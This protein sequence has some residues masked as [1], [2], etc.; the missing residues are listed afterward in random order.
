MSKSYLE[1]TKFKSYNER[2]EYLKILDNNAT[3]PRDR[4]AQFFKSKMW[5]HIREMVIERDLRFDLGVFG[6]YIDGPVYVHH[7]EPITEYD[8]EFVTDKLTSMNNLICTSM[9]THNAIHY[10]KKSEEVVE[11]FPGDTILW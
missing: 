11:R 4:S 8:L 7:I 5:R 6:M 2:L 9:D 1:M 3:S 10:K